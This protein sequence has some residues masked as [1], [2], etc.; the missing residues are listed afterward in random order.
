[1]LFSLVGGRLLCRLPLEGLKFPA[2]F[3]RKPPAV[4]DVSCNYRIGLDCGDARSVNDVVKLVCMTG[5][6]IRPIA[7]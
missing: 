7:D 4:E 6:R 2:P 3:G 5:D 1:M